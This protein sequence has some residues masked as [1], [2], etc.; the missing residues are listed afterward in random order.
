MLA[1]SKP[2]RPVA[3]ADIADL[4][5]AIGAKLPTDV[6]AFYKL[7]NGGVPSLDFLPARDQW[8]PMEVNSFLPIRIEADE[9]VSR[10]HRRAVE[11]GLMPPN[12]VPLAIDSGNNYYCLDTGNSSIVYWMNDVYD[13]ALSIEDNRRKALRPLYASFSEFVSDLMTEDDAYG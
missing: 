3:E 5:E 12:L 1:L 2:A 6:V 9:S 10:V 13:P 7:H 11:R 8:E 4:E